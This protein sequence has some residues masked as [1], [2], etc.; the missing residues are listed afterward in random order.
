MLENILNSL[1][2]ARIIDFSYEEEHVLNKLSLKMPFYNEAVKIANIF[3]D[4]KIRP[5]KIEIKGE[6]L[7]VD[8]QIKD[9][10]IISNKG[11][12]VRLVD[13][14]FNY[15]KSLGFKGDVLNFGYLVDV[16]PLYD[17]EKDL[18]KS[19]VVD[20]HFSVENFNFEGKITIICE[21]EDMLK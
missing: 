2:N 17:K 12:E 4:S 16:S 18:L 5:M 1:N 13:E 8:W 9:N 7:Y 6:F 10:L 19:T 20:P 15:V 3:H 14:F 21:S 11:E